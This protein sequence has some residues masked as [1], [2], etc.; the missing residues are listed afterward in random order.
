M[1]IPLTYLSF[2]RSGRV[3]VPLGHGGS[4]G[5]VC[6][7]GW[8]VRETMVRTVLVFYMLPKL[9]ASTT[10]RTTFSIDR[11]TQS[12]R[13]SFLPNAI[14]NNQSTSDWH[15]WSIESCRATYIT[16]WTDLDAP[17]MALWRKERR[18]RPLAISHWWRLHARYAEED[19][20][21]FEFLALKNLCG[22]IQVMTMS[23]EHNT[24]S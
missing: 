17:F 15:C 23:N 6:G 3:E 24:Y 13:P 20:A 4:W 12:R 19:N 10:R 8:G 16:T 11:S 9:I 7:D 22:S 21:S 14:V 5:T 2:V 1:L 18:D